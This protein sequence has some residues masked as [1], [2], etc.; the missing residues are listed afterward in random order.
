MSP[1]IDI[2]V[3]GWAEA[4]RAWQAPAVRAAIGTLPQLYRE[5]AA[6]PAGGGHVAWV[7]AG[8]DTWP[9]AVAAALQAGPA[10]VVVDQPTWA[11]PDA[12]GQ[13]ER[14]AGTVPVILAGSRTHAPQVRDLAALVEPVK[15]QIEW[16][17]ALLVGGEASLF[18]ALATLQAAGLAVVTPPRLTA[19]PHGFV[20]EATAG[21]AARAGVHLTVLQGAGYTPQAVIK[22]FGS[23][24]SLAAT[25]GDPLV[26]YPGEVIRIDQ[27]GYRAEPTD[28]QTPRRVA[29]REVHAAVAGSLV[30]PHRLNSYVP[31]AAL[32]GSAGRLGTEPAR[33]SS[34]GRSSIQ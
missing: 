11:T 21:G 28:Y 19:S 18:D 4:G 30:S 2:V 32:A 27:S 31:V 14:A 12:I 13:V 26:A 33:Q 1:R 5:V 22:A 20:V 24:G 16:V 25:A 17:D 6:P 9:D 3:S 7:M 29:L 15:D 23:F 34:D 8:G 10:A